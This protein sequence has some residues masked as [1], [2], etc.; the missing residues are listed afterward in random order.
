MH[1][2]LYADLRLSQ[3]AGFP[4]VK[5]SPQMLQADDSFSEIQQPSPNAC[6]IVSGLKTH[7]GVNSVDVATPFAMIVIE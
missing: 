4:K 5:I 3:S 2:C 7:F 1:Q 6:L